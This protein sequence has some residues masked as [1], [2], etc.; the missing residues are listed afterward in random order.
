MARALNDQQRKEI[1]D[2]YDSGDT[3][4]KIKKKTGLSYC[5]IMRVINSAGRKF[6]G[7]RITASYYFSEE[8]QRDSF[9]ENCF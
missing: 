4:N 8:T 6:K 5:S 2:L 9:L 7:E 3:W 1:I